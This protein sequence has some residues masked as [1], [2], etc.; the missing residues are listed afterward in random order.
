M[1][2]LVSIQL[3]KDIQPIA[4][5]DMIECATVLGWKVVVKKDEFKIGDK[6]VYFE[7]DS[8]LPIDEKYEFLRSSSYRKHETLGEGFRIKTQKRRGQLSQG[9]VLS[10]FDLGLDEN[11]PVNTDVT[12]LLHVQKWEALEKISDFGLLKDGLPDGI[13]S[14]DETRVQSIY[15]D[16]INEFRGLEYYITTKI[17]GTSMT[18]YMK[19]NYFGVC[20]HE[21][22]CIEDEKIPS[23]LWNYARTR[24]L[25]DKFRE[26]GVDNLAIQG[27]LAGP[28]IQGNR[29]KLNKL[30]WFVFT[31]KDLSTGKRLPLDE[32]VEICNKIGIDMVPIEE[33]DMD[34]ISN[35]PTLDSLLERAKGKYAS[36]QHK[37]GIV[38]RPVVPVH[39]NVVHGSL[40]MKVLNN[41]FLLK[42]K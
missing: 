25:E 14:T 26:A 16:V 13:S 38:I 21:N 2:N 32:M 29:L 30:N 42:E 19:N 10:L 12:E 8:Y 41:D 33:R 36:G 3:I 1:R 35:Y 34:L 20:S 39:S 31:I 37:E 22:E 24:N 23:S 18:V 7:V 6:C 11:L 17:D 9:L 40:S 27:E 28:G 15:D 5:A 4:D